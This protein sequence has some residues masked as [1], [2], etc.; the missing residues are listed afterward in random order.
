MSTYNTLLLTDFYKLTHM[1][2]YSPNIVRMTSYFVPRGS[3]LTDAGIYRV[4][5]FGLNAFIKK[6]LCDEFT[7]NFFARPWSTIK[8][9]VTETLSNG[10]G[11]DVDLIKKTLCEIKKLHSIG[12][13]PVEIN[14]LPEGTLCPMG[15]PCI[16]LKSTNES[17]P[18]A[19]QAIEP[20]LSAALWHP[21]V[22]ATVAR[23][24]AKIAREA[25]GQTVFWCDS[26][27]YK[28]GMCDFSMR[29]QESNESAIMSSV[30]WL[31]AMNNSS[32]VMARSV[33]KDVYEDH[34]LS[35]VTPV[36]GLTST[37][38]SVMTTQAQIDGGDETGT[39]ERL[40]KLYKNISFAAVCD[41]YDFWNVLTNILP[42]FKKTI[43]ERGSRGKFIGVRHDSADPVE[44]ICGIENAGPDASWE[45]KGMVQTIYELFGGKKNDLGFIELNP[46]IKAVYGDSITIP[47]A[48]EIYRRLKE[49]G[50]AANCVSLGVGS[51][52]FQALEH[53]NQL[54]PYT[55]DTFQI[56]CK[57]THAVIKDELRDEKEIF[58][59]KDPK[60][61]SMKKSHRGLCYVYYSDNNEMIVGLDEFTEKRLADFKE[62]PGACGPSLLVPYF[63][64]GARLCPQKFNDIRSKIYESLKEN[65]D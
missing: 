59:Y 52:S 15:V 50:F 33:I 21:M 61:F 16:E 48:K 22:S 3:R 60:G 49:K 65:Y 56:A 8:R 42:R 55:R 4:V 51:F 45:Q 57:C 20:A 43:N 23:Q 32:T 18:W 17:V 1:L 12:Y 10:L 41:S 36:C 27:R 37:E 39:F 54:L 30:A 26:E 13:L 9:E 63:K 25:Y 46:G 19:A 7:T 34:L 14:A 58:V 11:Y 35:V 2:Q 44:A 38:H 64:D 40:F 31:T 47:R 62:N 5:F 29:G 28:N 53:G 24:Y 6:Y